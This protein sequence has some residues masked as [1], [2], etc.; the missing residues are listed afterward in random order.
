MSAEVAGSLPAASG[1]MRQRPAQ[2]AGAALVLTAGVAWAVIALDPGIMA[3]SMPGMDPA[4]SM[5]G[6]GSTGPTITAGAA[7]AFLGAWTVMM[8]AMMLPSAVPMIG[9]Y[10]T[11][12]TS[13]SARSGRPA[14]HTTG[15]AAVYLAVWSLTGVPVYVVAA[16]VAKLSARHPGLHRAGPYAV[17]GVLVGA[18]AYQLSPVKLACLRACRGPLQFLSQRWRHGVTGTLRVGAEHAVYCL[19]CCWALMVVLVAAGAMGLAW[20]LLVAALVFVEKVLPGGDRASAFIGA[21]LVVLGAMVAIHSGVL[22][23]IRL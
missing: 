19:G 16:E 5:P 21:A 22:H 20:T 11:V 7:A 4:G 23:Q 14:V 13:M 10:A 9:L 8:A 6:M 3:S 18:G 15:F 2:M 1:R 17:A 12:R